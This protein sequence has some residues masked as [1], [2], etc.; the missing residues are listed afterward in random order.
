MR[1][2]AGVGLLALV[3]CNQLFSLAPTREFDAAVPPDVVP[4]IPYVQLTY[5]VARVLPSGAPDPLIT[6]AAITPP[7]QVR[8][9][10]LDGPFEPVSYSPGDGKIEIPRSYLEAK[11]TWRLEYTIGDGASQGVPHEIHW[12]PEDK[13]GHLTVPLM[14][15]LERDPPPAEGGYAVKP[16]GATRFTFPAILTTGLWTEGNAFIDTNDPGGTTATLNFTT[17]VSLSGPKGRPDPMRGDRA[18]LVDYTAEPNGCRVAVGSALLGSAAV[19][20]M[21]A[22]QMPQWDSGRLANAQVDVLNPANRLL[23]GLDKLGTAVSGTLHFGYVPNAGVPGL[24]GKPPFGALPTPVM[25]TMLTCPFAN[26]PAVPNPL[27]MS[28]Q[29]LGLRSFPRILHVQLIA[30]R[31]VLGVLLTSG[32]ETVVVSDASGFTL[33]FPAAIPTRM[34]LTT[35]RGILDLAGATEQVDVGPPTGTFTL[36]FT[37]EVGDG[38]RADHHEVLLHRLSDPLLITQRIYTVTQPTVRIDAAVLLPGTDYVF[39]IRSFKGHP[40]AARGNFAP[41]EYPYGAAI[42]F[43]RTFKTAP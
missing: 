30:A 24:A 3:G 39:E 32:M 20:A 2:V 37:P 29:P 41:I 9:A 43:T 35:S 13:V 31:R 23:A 25:L 33:S 15:R 10:P 27:P 40:D 28:A 18:L 16:A 34:T 1:C 19:E 8:I 11:K 4:D 38:L 12:N 14:G 5:Q 26:P 21:P 42:V 36:D 6:F 22:V 7:P 17:A